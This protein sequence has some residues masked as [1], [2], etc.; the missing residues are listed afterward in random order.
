MG[1]FV[2]TA[3]AAANAAA[4]AAT[5]CQCQKSMSIESFRRHVVLRCIVTVD[6]LRTIVVHFHGA[7]IRPS[8]QRHMTPSTLLSS[9]VRSARG[10]RTTRYRLVRSIV[11]RTPSDYSRVDQS[12]QWPGK[13][14]RR[15][16]DVWRIHGVHWTGC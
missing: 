7:S 6:G 4:A 14:D 10:H 8:V 5:A 1:A 13:M 3:A 2:R 9:L 12:G 15:A 11:G 16:A